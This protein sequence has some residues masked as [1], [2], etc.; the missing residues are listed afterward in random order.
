MNSIS[1]I[2]N[3]VKD[4]EVRHLPSGD[5]IGNFTI[6]V[7]DG[8]GEKKHVSYFDVAVFGKFVEQ[9]AKYIGKGSKVAIE[10]SLRQ[11]RWESN[12]QKRSKVKVVAG[13]IEY[14]D[15]KPKQDDDSEIP[16]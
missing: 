1:I 15:G 8:Y 2:G 5:P 6:A 4:Y 3:L 9:H 10:G 7:N 12:G 11:E 14:L 13:R 16:F